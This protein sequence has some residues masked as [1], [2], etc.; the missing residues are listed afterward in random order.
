MLVRYF[1][2]LRLSFGFPS[3]PWGMSLTVPF[4]AVEKAHCEWLRLAQGHTAVKWQSWDKNLGYF[5]VGPRE[6]EKTALVLKVSSVARACLPSVTSG[7][8]RRMQKKTALVCEA[9]E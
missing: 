8:E 5:L 4:F 1:Y 9:P 3:R 7:W 2:L 6:V